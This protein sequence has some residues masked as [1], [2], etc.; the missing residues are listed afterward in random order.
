[1]FCFQAGALYPCECFK[2]RE[3]T[4]G[5]TNGVGVGIS[6]LVWSSWAGVGLGVGVGRG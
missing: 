1:M 6:S 5:I 3:F 2:I 4:V